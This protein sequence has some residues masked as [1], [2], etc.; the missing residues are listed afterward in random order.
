M[1]RPPLT[2]RQIAMRAVGKRTARARWLCERLDAYVAT[3][4]AMKP[5]TK[6]WNHWLEK[7]DAVRE[8]LRTLDH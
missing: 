1:P 6:G 8:E 7:A 3:A 2:K 5:G 4:E